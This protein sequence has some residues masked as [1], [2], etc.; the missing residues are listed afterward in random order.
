MST[1]IDE[2]TKKLIK[3]ETGVT[4]AHDIKEMKKRFEES[5]KKDDTTSN[6]NHLPDEPY[7]PTLSSLEVA[8]LDCRFQMIRIVKEVH[9]LFVVLV[10]NF[11]D[12]NVL[13][14]DAVAEEPKVAIDSDRVGQFLSPILFKQL[15]PVCLVSLRSLKC[16][17]TDVYRAPNPVQQKR[18]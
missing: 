17:L 11:I 7:E 6:F 4:T 8:R 5:L 18:K 15:L 9:R 13:Q 10:W 2:G 1:E 14:V 12:T 3:R 16:E